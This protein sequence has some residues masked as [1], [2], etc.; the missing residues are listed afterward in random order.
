M[1]AQDTTFFFFLIEFFYVFFF[2]RRGAQLVVLEG[3]RRQ[4][5]D[6]AW[7]DSCLDLHLMSIGAAQAM[8]HAWL[9]NIRSV[10][11]EGH[12]LPKLLRYGCLYKYQILTFQR[13]GSILAFTMSKLLNFICYS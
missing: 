4:V 1:C 10:V 11:F 12:E 9:L 5:W 6:N 8:V 2:Q 3:K 13:T 7:L